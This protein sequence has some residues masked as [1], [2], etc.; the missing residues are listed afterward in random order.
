MLFVVII[1]CPGAG[2]G[3]S[4]NPGLTRIPWWI[5]QTPQGIPEGLPVGMPLGILRGICRGFPR[6]IPMGI[7]PGGFAWGGLS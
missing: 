3:I 2:T 4:E 1:V 5:P 7:L 6:G